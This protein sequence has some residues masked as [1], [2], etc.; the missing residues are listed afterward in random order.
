MNLP[1]HTT[2]RL[3]DRISN[4]VVFK[5][6]NATSEDVEKALDLAIQRRQNRISSA[7][8]LDCKD[9]S[10]KVGGFSKIMMI[11]FYNDYSI[12]FLLRYLDKM[13]WTK[14]TPR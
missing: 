1:N 13:K 7:I 3:I 2:V 6:E 14:I 8:V 9:A 12:E 5:Q 4:E 10:E 11:N